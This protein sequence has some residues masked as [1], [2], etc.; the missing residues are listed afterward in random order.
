MRIDVVTLFPEWFEQLT[1]LGVTGRAVNTENIQLVTW[2]PRDFTTNKHNQVDD[3]PY[4][5]GPGMVM[6]AEPLA[7][8]LAAIKQ[9]NTV[10]APV[11]VMSPQGRAFNQA[12]AQQL[13]KRPRLI[14]LCG[15]YEGIDQRLLDT[16]VDEHWSL[17]DYV[18]S[19][20][21]L[22]AAIVI[23]AVLRLLPGV[24]G[25][26]QSAE[27]DSFSTGPA[28]EQGLLDCPH[29]TRP[30]CWQGQA[31]PDRLL[32]GNH[33]AIADWRRQQSLLATW[34]E[35]PELLIDATLSDTDRR[36]LA[37]SI[38]ADVSSQKN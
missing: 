3:R 34:K 1:S 27:Q 23:D 19:G 37:E 16:C 28:G 11:S 14:L 33:A 21:E 18:I 29:Y 22:A 2:N 9:Q 26:A 30:E 6:M 7:L 13:A 12:A 15:R 25:H 31:V 20:G 5:G 38:T 8:T 10:D 4:G 17:G 36:L 35:R 24:L 32:S